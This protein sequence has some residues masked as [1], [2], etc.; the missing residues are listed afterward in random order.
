MRPARMKDGPVTVLMPVHNGEATVARALR[1]TLRALPKNAV[2]L[3]HDDGSTDST[4]EILDT[5]AD[6][7]IEVIRS[8]QQR[9]VAGG[10]NL[11]LERVRTPLVARMDADDVALP[12]RFRIQLYGIA[13]GVDALFST[14]ANVGDVGVGSVRLSPPLPITA[15]AFPFHLLISN[16]V[17]HST[18]LAKTETLVQAGGYFDT[19]AQD[20]ELWMRL[21]AAGRRCRRL[22]TPTV[23]Y[24]FHPQQVTASTDYRSRIFTE[25]VFARA[26]RALSEKVLKREA[27]WYDALHTDS[28]RTP[29]M[30][31]QLLTFVTA[32]QEASSPLPPLQRELLRRKAR[33]LLA[34]RQ[35]AA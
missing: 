9:G 26:Y 8:N 27:T 31:E 21:S 35:L 25:Q 1:S 20:Y 6:P 34:D 5:V 10:L 29:Q 11:M 4:P 30:R 23:L 24:R 12:W 13:T 28:E 7:R 2:L 14:V 33:A 17:A 3:V 16:P 15:A 32:V 22:A 19:P 18:L